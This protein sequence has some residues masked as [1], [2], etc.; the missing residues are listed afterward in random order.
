[1]WRFCGVGEF[2]KTCSDHKELP[3]IYLQRNHVPYNRKQSQLIP[4]SFHLHISPCAHY[5]MQSFHSLV[6]RSIENVLQGIGSCLYHGFR[7][8]QFHMHNLQGNCNLLL[9]DRYPST[10]YCNMIPSRYLDIVFLK[11]LPIPLLQSVHFLHTNIY[12]LTDFLPV[13]QYRSALLSD[14]ASKMRY[15][16]KYFHLFETRTYFLF[17]FRSMTFLNIFFGFYLDIP[18]SCYRCFAR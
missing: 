16:P 14:S 4:M 10:R 18:S 13:K 3:T 6:L 17:A 1:M 15:D 5:A 12:S 2:N 9:S 7:G 11:N 8:L